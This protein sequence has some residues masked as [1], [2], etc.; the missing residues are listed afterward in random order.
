M[1]FCLSLVQLLLLICVCILTGCVFVVCLRRADSGAREI[2]IAID[3]RDIPAL[4]DFF[5]EDLDD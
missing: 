4:L 2:L 3:P 5:E 1:E